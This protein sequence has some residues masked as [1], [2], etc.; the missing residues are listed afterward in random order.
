MAKL[1]FNTAEDKRATESKIHARQI[2]VDGQHPLAVRRIPYRGAKNSPL[3]KGEVVNNKL[4]V[5]SVFFD[6]DGSQAMAEKQARLQI[7]PVQ[8]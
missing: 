6:F 7:D 2:N 1:I 4:I 3:L 5:K 8:G